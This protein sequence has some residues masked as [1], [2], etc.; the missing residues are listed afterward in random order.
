MKLTHTLLIVGIFLTVPLA[1]STVAQA[2]AIENACVDSGRRGATRSLCTC[3]QTVA[4]KT[5]T[6]RDQRVA[7]GFFK[8]PHRAQELRQSDRNR[9]EDFWLRY[10]AFG[11]AASR[12]CG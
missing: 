1:T 5:L 4:D 3:I 12:S 9:D 7:A 11:S 2:G 8:D 10:K 6:R